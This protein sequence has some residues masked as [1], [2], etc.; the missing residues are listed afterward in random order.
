MNRSVVERES[1]PFRRYFDIG[2][3]TQGDSRA[4]GVTYAFICG[5]YSYFVLGQEYVFE[6][7]KWYMVDNAVR[8]Y[9]RSTSKNDV[10]F[11]AAI[12]DQNTEEYYNYVDRNIFSSSSGNLGS[13]L[14][15]HKVP[16]CTRDYPS[17]S[18]A[19]LNYTKLATCRGINPAKWYLSIEENG[20]EIHQYGS[21]ESGFDGSGTP[22]WGEPSATNKRVIYQP[23]TS[24]QKSFSFTK[25]QLESG[26]KLFLQPWNATRYSSSDQRFYIGGQRYRMVFQEID[27]QGEIIW[28][29]PTDI[30]SGGVGIPE[31]LNITCVGIC[32]PDTCPVDCGDL[33]EAEAL[34]DRICCYGSNGIATY[35]Y[36]K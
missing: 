27:E 17:N 9:L 19:T 11:L 3:F 10:D 26:I 20:T 15:L 7:N 2:H 35:S 8:R 34:R 30:L 1:L 29:F 21:P 5:Y 36:L 33:S 4:C 25:T 13:S 32:P 23:S 31:D 16:N 6:N 12:E 14:T 28:T 24:V 22:P 18:S